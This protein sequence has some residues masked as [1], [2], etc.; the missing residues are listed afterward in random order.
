MTHEAII[1]P[2][3]IVGTALVGGG[4]PALAA[5]VAERVM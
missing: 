3:V 2:A 5:F 4:A 1:E